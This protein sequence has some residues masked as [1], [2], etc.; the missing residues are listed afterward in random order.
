[1]PPDCCDECDRSAV[2]FGDAALYANGHPHAVLEGLRAAAP[3]H[4]LSS[5]ALGHD[6]WG[7]FRAEQAREVLADD[8]TFVSGLGVFPWN[9]PHNPDP[10]RG[11]ILIAS[12][13]ARR[14]TVR[15]AVAGLFTRQAVESRRPGPAALFERL[16]APRLDGGAFDFGS[17]VARPAAMA[18]VADL[19]G[20]RAE[21]AARV[22]EQVAGVLGD[23]GPVEGVRGDRA[24]AGGAF[25]RAA[26]V[27]D[28]AVAE[29]RGADADD[30]IGALERARRSGS[31][32]RRD[33]LS[34]LIG[35]VVGG[36]EAPRLVLTG[37][38]VVLAHRP[39][40]H[41]RLREDPALLPGF[42][43]E[44]LRWTAPTTMVGRTAARDVRLGGRQVRRGDVVR[45]MLASVCRDPALHPDP[46]TF[47]PRRAGRADLAFGHG[48][49]RCLGA[50]PARAQVAALLETLVR[51]DARLVPAGPTTGARS[52]AFSG[53][54]DA[55]LVLRRG[56]RRPDPTAPDAD[57]ARSPG[58]RRTDTDQEATP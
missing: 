47:D 52:N 6:F 15:A 14:A 53:H 2:D 46:G 57:P 4:R 35:V 54:L 16:L 18:A 9:G 30:V 58:G 25:A 7:V 48:P 41:D 28:E 55:R 19:V 50:A 10:L 5:P 36:T 42:V 27:L 29:R 21:H 22:D 20:L 31:L 49:H 39:D 8:R 11:S 44:A 51:L 13:G 3:V 37:V 17:D 43:D 24:A 32:S 23:T 40:W 38:A 1:M 33:V 26:Q 12:D 45:V 56:A 34:N